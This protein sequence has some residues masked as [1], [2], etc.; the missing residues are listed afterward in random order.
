MFKQVQGI[1]IEILTQRKHKQFFKAAD[2][3]TAIKECSV[4]IDRSLFMFRVSAVE[5]NTALLNIT[6]LA[7]SM[8]LARDAEYAKGSVTFGKESAS[9]QVA[10]PLQSPS[11]PP[12]YTQQPDFPDSYYSRS[13]VWEDE[14]DGKE[15][16]YRTD[17]DPYAF[18]SQ[19]REIFQSFFKLFISSQVASKSF[20]VVGWF[21][22]LHRCVRALKYQMA[23]I[24]IT[25]SL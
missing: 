18:I 9:E 16:L 15:Q 14:T 2:N 12:V 6:Q 23:L 20:S 3:S 25:V 13:E 4:E 24:Q 22:D 11:E 19:V 10:S 1:I 7:V 5:F 8:S 17:T 21:N